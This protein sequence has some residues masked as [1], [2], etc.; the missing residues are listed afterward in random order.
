MI[1]FFNEYGLKTVITSHNHGN[2]SGEA[3]LI[4]DFTDK[5]RFPNGM[6]DFSA[7]EGFYG[8]ICWD[9]PSVNQYEKLAA[10]AQMFEEI[11]SGT[12]AKFIVNLL[13]SYGTESDFG[14]LSFDEY[15]DGYGSTVLSQLLNT[16]KCFSLDTYPVMADGSFGETFLTDLAKLKAASLKYKAT[17]HVCLQ[18]SATVW[19]AES[20]AW[21]KKTPTREELGVQMY[22]AL[23]FGIDSVS[24]YSYVDPQEEEDLGKHGSPVDFETGNKNAAY[25][26]LK[27]V[28]EEVASYDYVLS[29]FSWT[30]FLTNTRVSVLKKL[31]N[32]NYLK[33]YYITASATKTLSS[34]SAGSLF[35]PVPYVMGRMVDGDGNEGFMISC[36]KTSKN[37]ASGKT[38]DLTLNFNDGINKL[39]IWNNGVKSEIEVSGSYTLNLAYG[40]GAFVIPYAG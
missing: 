32:Q 34:V 15:L 11:Y 18:S 25:D 37:I 26:D 38:Y 1:S 20:S 5:V 22:S 24:W 3:Y 30:G 40:G 23:A 12:D 39:I 29:K 14:A 2:S 9:E 21:K 31:S 36:Y 17:S 35:N 7:S 33:N 27:A 10:F 19:D 28:N 13:P 6:P 16:E 4:N 8:F